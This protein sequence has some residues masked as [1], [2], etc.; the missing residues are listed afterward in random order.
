[1]KVVLSFQ[2]SLD[3]VTWQSCDRL[4]RHH[5]CHQTRSTP[6]SP[7]P[8]C[9]DRF[10]HDPPPTDGTLPCHHALLRHDSFL[11]L[12]QIEHLHPAMHPSATESRSTA[13]TG[14]PGLLDHRVH[15]PRPVPSLVVSA[16]SRLSG[17][18]LAHL[19]GCS[20]SRH[21][22]L[23]CR[24]FPSYCPE[25][26]HPGAECS[27]LRHERL[28]LLH[29][30]YHL[31]REVTY[32]VPQVGVLCLALHNP[33]V[34]SG[35]A[36]C[37]PSILLLS[38]STAA[39]GLTQGSTEG[40]GSQVIRGGRVHRGQ[41]MHLDERRVNPSFTSTLISYHRPNSPDTLY[42]AWYHRGE[43]VF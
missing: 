36:V 15:L 42:R 34:L 22:L 37:E 41:S 4:H 7:D 20:E 1:M 23:G 25:A 10:R 31:G 27:H 43:I 18:L 30:R 12:G 39:L 5:G 9:R 13:R 21:V 2:P 17:C 24:V 3:H 14:I 11:L 38:S 19:L 35:H 40:G 6:C 26:V 16:L 8:S 29:Q 32:L 28:V 33:S